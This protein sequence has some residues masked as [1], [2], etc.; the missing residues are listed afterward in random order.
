MAS[1]SDSQSH[2]NSPGQSFYVKDTTSRFEFDQAS[3]S[4]SS[5]FA[6]TDSEGT[7]TT[8]ESSLKDVVSDYSMDSPTW[9]ESK[10]SI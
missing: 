7:T 2:P 8:Y 5:R 1:F 3:H 10:V 6:T 4:H 9:S